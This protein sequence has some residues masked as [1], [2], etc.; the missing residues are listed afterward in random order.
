MN[1]VLCR[2]GLANQMIH[3]MFARYLELELCEPVYIDNSLYS[4]L[5]MHNGF[6]L[7]KI[8]PNIQL[9]LLKDLYSEEDW[10]NFVTK[11]LNKMPITKALGE[12]GIHKIIYISD[13][14]KFVGKNTLNVHN[15]KNKVEINKI[16][17]IKNKYFRTC[18]YDDRYFNKIKEQMLREL[19]FI[20]ISKDDFQNI[21]YMKKIKSTNS[22]AIHVRRGDF[23]TLGRDI[24]ANKF[25]P[26]VNQIRENQE[27][28]SFFIFSDD[29]PWC[30]DNLMELGLLQTDDVTL[31]EGNDIDSKNYIDMQL[32]LKCKYIISNIRSSFSRVASWLNQDLIEYITIT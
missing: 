15:F 10:D 2:S 32:M 9:K 7:N 24:P 4:A 12:L 8:F 20:D 6:E 30:K 28:L 1:I 29:I 25:A 26:S 27:I 5:E 23:V 13:E 22:V 16:S 11:S 18:N 31:I 3:Y 21:D 17:Y 14:F 19:T